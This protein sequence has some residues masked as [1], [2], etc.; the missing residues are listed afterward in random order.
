M[1]F[2]VL[3]AL[4]CILVLTIIIIFAFPRFSPIPYFPSNKKDMSLILP[5]LQLKNKQT[6]IDLGAGDGIV[7]FKA[8]DIAYH[9]A[10][11]T[12]F[13]AVE[14]N[15]VLLLIL[16]LRRLFHPNRKN[17][18]IVKADM[19]EIDYSLYVSKSNSFVTFY[20]YISPWYIEK[21]ILNIKKQYRQFDVVSY[22]YQVKC[23]SRHAEKMKEGIH[24]LYSYR[25]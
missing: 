1:I 7:I 18:Y 15:P 8:A 25:Q 24:K 3:S 19:F 23:L 22:F 17:I 2:Y 13:I 14:I 11:D 5:A 10:L 4:L 6:V 20:I 16:S 12:R 21:T 9:K